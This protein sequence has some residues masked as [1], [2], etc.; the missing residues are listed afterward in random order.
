[1][2]KS[3]IYVQREKC[4]L[5]SDVRNSSF[6]SISSFQKMQ[7]KLWH[8]VPVRKKEIHVSEQI[9]L[10][11]MLRCATRPAGHMINWHRMRISFLERWQLMNAWKQLC[12]SVKFALKE[13]G[14]NCFDSCLAFDT[15]KVMRFWSVVC[16]E[17]FQKLAEFVLCVLVRYISPN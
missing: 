10:R 11:E 14:E 16:E 13:K 2:W 17:S 4:R 6:K 9:S 15:L 5:P 12:Y 7:P 3:W 8:N 1:M